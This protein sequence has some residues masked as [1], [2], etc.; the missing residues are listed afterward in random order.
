MS[1]KEFTN[2]KRPRLVYGLT[3]F[4]QFRSSCYMLK[5]PQIWKIC[6]ND[7]ADMH[8]FSWLI[9]NESR[10]LKCNW[11]V[12]RVQLAK[13]FLCFVSAVSWDLWGD[14]HFQKFL[15]NNLFINKNAN[16]LEICLKSGLLFF[17]PWR[18]LTK[19]HLNGVDS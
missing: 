9:F 7:N 13:P 18:Y 2:H 12:N 15:I 19:I 11:T 8:L 6:V 16:L 1:L 17:F 10:C 14:R 3:N 4:Y 5:S